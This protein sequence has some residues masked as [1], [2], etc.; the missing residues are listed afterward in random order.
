[1]YLDEVRKRVIDIDNKVK[2]QGYCP[3][4]IESINGIKAMEELIAKLRNMDMKLTDEIKNKIYEG[5]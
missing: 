2:H 4:K 3:S 5:L 1:L